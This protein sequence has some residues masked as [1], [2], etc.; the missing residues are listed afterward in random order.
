MARAGFM[1]TT[2]SF[3]HL[4]GLS[5]ATG[6][7]PKA[8][9]SD[10]DKKKREE[11]EA[12][13]GKGKAK[14][15]DKPDD[16]G[17]DESDEGYKERKKREQEEADAKAEDDDDEM[18]KD[19]KSKA[20]R[21]RERARCAAIFMSPAAAARPDMAAHLAFGTNMSRKDAVASLEVAAQGASPRTGPTGRSSLTE[22]MDRERNPDVRPDAETGAARPHQRLMAA[23]AKATGKK[24]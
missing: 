16:Q 9:E 10:E 1:A 12:A 22:R 17:E 7:R 18:D 24:P 6:G 13:K 8:E 11:E 2:S 3:A 5:G 23:H 15:D 19:P 21:L 20:A 4:L 14:A